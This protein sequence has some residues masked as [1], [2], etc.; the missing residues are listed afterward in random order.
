AEYRLRTPGRRARGA[1]DRRRD[2]RDARR[3]GAGHRRHRGGVRRQLHVRHLPRLHRT[4]AARATPRDVRRGRRAARRHGQRAPA[5]QPLEL[6]D[7][8]DAG[9]GRLG[10]EPARTAGV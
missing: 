6:P 5:Q 9:D 1:G 10:G 2:E 3:H 8:S 4:V 7:R